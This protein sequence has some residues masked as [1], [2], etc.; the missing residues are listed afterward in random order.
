MKKFI[1]IFI[2][3]LFPF[4]FASCKNELTT[5]NAYVISKI[6]SINGFESLNDETIK[7]LSIIYKNDKLE[8]D[9]NYKIK[10][11]EKLLKLINSTK[12]LNLE[13]PISVNTDTSSWEKTLNKSDILKFYQTLNIEL[14][15]VSDINI[16][17]NN[18]NFAQSLIVAN[19]EVDFIL[20]SKYFNLKSN[21]N[22][23]F[24]NNSNNLTFYGYGCGFNYDYELD[25]IE[26]MANNGL[27]YDEIIKNMT[28]IA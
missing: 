7:T 15:N 14:S 13:K 20:F 21:K 24:T 17:S 26:S 2:I 4:I 19:K 27:K 6:Q 22:I 8:N 25:N 1:Y 16:K 5:E 10:N 12:D 18:K 3:L 11:N 23:T 28:K 9:M